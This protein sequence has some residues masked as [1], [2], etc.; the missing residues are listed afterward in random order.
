VNLYVSP[1]GYRLMILLNASQNQWL[2]AYRRMLRIRP[3][4]EEDSPLFKMG[5]IPGLLLHVK[6]RATSRQ[7]SFMQDF[8]QCRMREDY[9]RQHIACRSE[10]HC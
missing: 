3:F 9:M 10:A 4:E 2:E 7:T 6:R 1:A 8:G 5:K